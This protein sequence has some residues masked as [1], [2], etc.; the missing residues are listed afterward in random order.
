ML[1]DEGE[2]DLALDP[3]DDALPNNGGML[4]AKMDYPGSMLI[5]SL[6]SRGT[7]EFRSVDLER[8]IQ[9]VTDPDPL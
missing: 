8:P 1:D 6:G 5:A 7:I 9:R 3:E 4:L 2:E